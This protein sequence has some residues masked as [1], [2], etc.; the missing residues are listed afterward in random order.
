[1]NSA[2]RWR[3]GRERAANYHADRQG[4][5][6]IYEAMNEAV[7]SVRAKRPMRDEWKQRVDQDYQKRKK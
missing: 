5:A 2:P 7:G 3:I 1:M 4:T 6:V